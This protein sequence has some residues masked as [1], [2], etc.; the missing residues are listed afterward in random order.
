MQSFFNAGRG[1][2]PAVFYKV[3]DDAHIVPENHA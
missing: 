2:A 3:G 1:L